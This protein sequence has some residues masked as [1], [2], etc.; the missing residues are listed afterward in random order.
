[1][2]KFTS[3]GLFEGPGEEL[4]ARVLKESLPANW[5]VIHARRLPDRNSTEIDFIV[6]G[7][8]Y[9]FVLEEKYWGPAIVLHEQYWEVIKP[10]GINDQRPSPLRQSL[11]ASRKLLDILKEN[12]PDFKN[13]VRNHT[14]VLP[15]FVVLSYENLKIIGA[16]PEFHQSRVFKLED[17]CAHLVKI[18]GDGSGAHNF[19]VARDTSISYL[20]GLQGLPRS[21]TSIGNFVVTKQ[22][23]D[24][25]NAKMFLANNV[26]TNKNTILRC[27][28]LGDD[29]FGDPRYFYNNE[30]NFLS[31][32]SNLN[33]S[34]ILGD[35]F[36]EE[37]KNWYIVPFTIPNG[38]VS[39]RETLVSNF[40]NRQ[41]DGI[42]DENSFSTFLLES[43]KALDEVCSALGEGQLA[44]RLLSPDR[45][46]VHPASNRF[47]FSDFFGAKLITSKSQID[48]HTVLNWIRDDVA[49]LWR[50][51]EADEFL[52]N[53][54]HKS[55]V[56]S[57]VLILCQWALGDFR[58]KV[59]DVLD[60]MSQYLL[61][62]D[63]ITKALD[64][65]PS[66]RPSSSQFISELQ[67]LEKN[68]NVKIDEESQLT[69]KVDVV[70][71]GRFTIKRHLGTGGFANAWLAQEAA[72]RLGRDVVIKEVLHPEH[73]A[74]H[75]S[76]V[77]KALDI[78]RLT[79]P[80]V[81]RLLE[82]IPDPLCLVYEYAKGE[83]LE[84]RRNLSQL[85]ID[86]YKLICINVLQ[87]LS[88][89]HENGYVHGDISSRNIIVD[90]D[91]QTCLIDF[92]LTALV[93]EH[94]RGFTRKFA[95]PEVIK[96]EP[97]SHLSDIYSFGV[98]I[99]H[100]ILNRFPY[101]TDAE[102]R[103]TF[104]ISYLDDFELSRFSADEVAFLEKLFKCLE[105]EPNARP[106]SA[107]ELKRML[108]EA[109]APQF[110][111]DIKNRSYLENPSV[112]YLR[113]NYRFSRDGAYE[114][115]G[116][117]AKN[118]LEESTYVG[119][120]LDTE[121]TPAILQNKVKIGILTGNPGDGK[122]AYLLTLVEEMKKINNSLT[123]LKFDKSGW[124]LKSGS[125]TIEAILD[126]SESHLGQS[127]D[128]RIFDALKRVESGNHTLLIA[129]NDGRM[130]KFFDDFKS[131]FPELY[132][133][134]DGFLYDQT[135]PT[136][137]G[138][139][140][141]DLKQRSLSML[142]GSGLA[143]E[144]LGK[145]TGEE[146]WKDCDGCLSQKQCPI[147]RNVTT[148]RENAVQPITK[149]V[150][151]SHLRRRRRATFRDLRSAF[152]WII[153]GDFSC[154][155]VNEATQDSRDLTRGASTRLSE[156]LFNVATDD[157]L[158]SEWNELDPGRKIFPRLER[159]LRK[160]GITKADEIS[161]IQREIYLEIDKR[162][163]DEFASMSVSMYNYFDDYINFLRNPSTEDHLSRILLGLS[164]ISSSPIYNQKGLAIG[165]SNL[166]SGWA[167]LKVVPELEFTLETNLT[168]SEYVESVPDVLILTHRGK[169]RLQISLNEFEVISAAAN[170]HVFDDD[171]TQAMIH[172]FNFFTSR[173]NN[174]ESNKVILIS[175]TGFT[176]E[177]NLVDG[178]IEM[179]VND[180]NTIA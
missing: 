121:L 9:I 4:T 69:L 128:N 59:S 95:S 85:S 28:D 8:N 122:T 11:N 1:M 135:A 106:Q 145:F 79:I 148:I 31:Q 75:E 94:L 76:E 20:N 123:V 55:D 35:P 168:H 71:D 91:F 29:S 101:A 108:I 19:R 172:E 43:M 80:G 13:H 65:D 42:L 88:G 107:L 177:V 64:P 141:I 111:E 124:V 100:S 131:D 48:A 98:V 10:S 105:P 179:Q 152:G 140:I 18:D 90:E 132:F 127:S 27:H 165:S 166:D 74:I 51:P 66:S 160:I 93:G 50:A 137:S 89:L 83:N 23:Q 144:V 33:R 161:Q 30:V 54:S 22:L 167:V 36:E 21:I 2:A 142:D 115:R 143:K 113:A 112:A 99:L 150:L 32:I 92:G 12:V 147:F 60:G 173:L 174:V 84:V 118:R 15:D 162:F 120:K 14:K 44:H 130:R 158:V 34:W 146:L 40:P 25:L 49:N 117:N 81:A 178:I 39:L 170:G 78:S 45:V 63:L 37:S 154:K 109:R 67:T 176:S 103:K 62:K 164:R 53:A 114:I 26:H 126:A 157:Y 102:S 82:R 175:P 134:V 104:E 153:T 116:Y 125:K 47:I 163:E 68:R 171:S 139:V 58:L 159:V 70:V 77:M 24:S 87:V 56:F 17:I 119:T 7:E 110:P 156:L 180:E 5:E 61:L 52:E 96:R 6:V 86:D 136:V 72:E 41:D 3:L 46:W 169:T 57:L 133:D 38:A 97:V 151:S 16:L 138:F 155:E 73:S 149:L 129:M